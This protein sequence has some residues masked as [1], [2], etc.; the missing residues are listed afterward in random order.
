MQIIIS[1]TTATA[2]NEYVHFAIE[3]K[4]LQGHLMVK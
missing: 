2:M 1:I 3:L 4:T